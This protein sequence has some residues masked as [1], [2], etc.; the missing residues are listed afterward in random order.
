MDVGHVGDYT[1]AV[2][3]GRRLWPGHDHAAYLSPRET[4]HVRGGVV[5]GVT[6]H[7]LLRKFP[8]TI[9]LCFSNCDIKGRSA[10][11]WVGFGVLPPNAELEIPY[12]AVV[13][14]GVDGLLIAGKAYSCT[15]DFLATA[16][17]QAD[18]QNQGGA[19]ALAAVQAVRR[20]V[21]PRDVDVA[22]LQVELEAR[23]VLPAGTARR[24]VNGAPPSADAVRVMVASLT[25]SE[26]FHLEQGFDDRITDP[27]M[28]VKLCAA[29]SDAV[30]VL[31]D[32]YQ[33]AAGPRRL[34]LA[35]ILAWHGAPDGVPDIV[36]AILALLRDG[37]LPPIAWKYRYAGVPPDNGVMPEACHLLH[38]L[39]LVPDE[40][41]LPVLE[42]IAE[43]FD[44]AV[45]EFRP[46]GGGMFYYADEAA[47]AAERWGDPRAIP[48]LRRLAGRAAIRG[49]TVTALE[50]DFIL[51]RLAYLELGV[52]RALA[53]C[54]SADGVRTL[55]GYLRDARE[56]FAAHARSEL[57]VVAGSDLGR[58]PGP[59][60]GWLA[61]QRE[62]LPPRA[63][64]TRID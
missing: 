55:I 36:S 37:V 5:L 30:P 22:A 31:R 46:K 32:A 7:V 9:N 48:P 4:R 12:R 40:R 35:R 1:R 26:P 39:A 64:T 10:A 16:R 15:H 38:A 23:G 19:I 34:L 62:P 42:R 20:G 41:M 60:E 61:G 14:E 43:L 56:L 8:D 3:A 63:W 33:G 27:L 25:G 45:D 6:D 59:W 57:A 29:G 50:P 54:G 17:M 21:P 53:R 49:R 18:M 52:A 44:P 2:L 28:I 11:D 47:V 51:D 24:P 58:A 13:P